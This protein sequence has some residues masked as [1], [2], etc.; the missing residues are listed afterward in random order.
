MAKKGRHKTVRRLAPEPGRFY[1]AS[2]IAGIAHV[3]LQLSFEVSSEPPLAAVVM[4]PPRGGCDHGE[5]DPAQLRAAVLEGV[6]GV[7]LKHAAR[8]RVET[9]R[10]CPD[11][12][13]RYPVYRDLAAK[14]S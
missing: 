5:I 10:Y 4:L 8:L 7:N 13:P 12:S 1:G 14:I 11:D 6:A 2:W 3:S 9:I